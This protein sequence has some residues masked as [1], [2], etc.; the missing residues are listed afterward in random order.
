V[1]HGIPEIR[2][3]RRTLRYRQLLVCRM[4]QMKNRVTGLL[5]ETEVSYNNQRLH[6]VG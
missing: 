3:R 5:M 4:V 6:K 1:P 2:D